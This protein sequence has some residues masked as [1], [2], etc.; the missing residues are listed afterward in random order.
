[1]MLVF[2]F[3]GT[4]C[5]E[6][7]LITCFI[8]G[9]LGSLTWAD[10]KPRTVCPSG[11]FAIKERSQWYCYKFYEQLFTFQEA[12]EECQFKCKGHLA[13]F[14]SDSQAKY[15]NTYVSRENIE[16]K[17]VWI[18]L[19]RVSGSSLNTGWRWNDGSL[20]RYTR[21]SSGEPNNKA[22][23][24]FCSTG[25]GLTHPAV[26]NFHFS[27]NGLPLKPSL[28]MELGGFPI[29]RKPELRSFGPT[30]SVCKTSFPQR[31]TECQA[32]GSLPLFLSL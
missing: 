1:M 6:M 7:L 21:W 27:A 13:S 17:W 32:A 25:I 14:I 22:K 12:E 8:F 23:D 5:L 28:K 4:S 15:I 16:N 31:P 26:R 20:S 3:I 9:L 24:E 11:S 2:C 18:G 19:Q 10:P 29:D 30:F